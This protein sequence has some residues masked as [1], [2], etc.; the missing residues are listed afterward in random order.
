MRHHCVIESVKQHMLNRRD[1]L[2]AA[3]AADASDVKNMTHELHDD[4]PTYFGK[5]GITLEQVFSFADNGFNLFSLAR[6]RQT[7]CCAG[8]P[9]HNRSARLSRGRSRAVNSPST[10]G[11][12]GT[13]RG[14][15]VVALQPNIS[16]RVIVQPVQTE[17]RRPDAPLLVEGGP[18]PSDRRQKAVGRGELGGRAGRG[19]HDIG[20]LKSPVFRR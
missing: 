14:F 1:L 9:T 3:P 10:S 4:F 13:H 2:K 19:M 16:Q 18:Y 12:L 8:G 17:Q 15:D 11:T 20:H 7:G 6:T 5:P